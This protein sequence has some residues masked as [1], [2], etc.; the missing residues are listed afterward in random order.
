[1]REALA[2]ALAVAQAAAAKAETLYEQTPMVHSGNHKI[3]LPVRLDH[4]WNPSFCDLSGAAAGTLVVSTQLAFPTG[5]RM[6]SLLAALAASL[7]GVD[8]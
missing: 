8:V 2:L 6:Q 1:M 4:R 3:P 7:L 5:A